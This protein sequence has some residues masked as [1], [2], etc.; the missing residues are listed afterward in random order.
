MDKLRKEPQDKVW[1]CS[2][3][4]DDF[5]PIPGFEFYVCQ[6]DSQHWCPAC[7]KDFEITEKKEKGDDVTSYED[8]GNCVVEYQVD[9]RNAQEIIGSKI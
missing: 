5:A 7:Y 2:G 1:N 8:Y 9:A 6:K 4:K 3:C